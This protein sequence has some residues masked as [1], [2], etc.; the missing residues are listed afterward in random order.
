MVRLE[1]SSTTDFHDMWQKGQIVCVIFG[2]ELIL[3]SICPLRVRIFSKITFRGKKVST[4][5]PIQ[6]RNSLNTE[7]NT[8]SEKASVFPYIFKMYSVVLSHNI[9]I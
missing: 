6:V 8:V 5:L 4:Y 9:C 7:K 1:D 3:L 2:E